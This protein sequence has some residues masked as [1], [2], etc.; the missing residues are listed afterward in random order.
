MPR[1]TDKERRDHMSEIV[2]EVQIQYGKSNRWGCGCFE[3]YA[4]QGSHH[5]QTSDMGECEPMKAKNSLIKDLR[6]CDNCSLY[7]K[8]SS[9]R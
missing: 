6:H 2:I 5:Q 7:R 9:G 1:Q 8:Q 3:G 4:V